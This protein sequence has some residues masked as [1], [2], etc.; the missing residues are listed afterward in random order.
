M[1]LGDH[2]KKS[3]RSG[4]GKKIRPA[5]ETKG[6]AVVGSGSR[7]D[8]FKR[9]ATR[10]AEGDM[11]V[12]PRMLSGNDRRLHVRQTI[13]E[14]HELRIDSR[15]ELAQE[16]FDKMAVSRYSF[17]R[18]TCLLFY[19]DMAGEDAWMPTVL[20]L[21]DVHPGNFGVMPSRDNVPFFGVN[22]F[23]ESYYAPFTWDLKRGALGFMLSVA[24]MGGHGHRLQTGA[25][26]TFVVGYLEA[27]QEYATGKHERR[28][29]LR[30]DNAPPLIANLLEN[31]GRTSR[32]RWLAD[33]YLDETGLRFRNSEKLVPV[34]S[35]REEFQA[36][37]DR[38]VRDNELSPPPRAAKMRVKDVCV[39]KGQGTASLGLARYYV[40]IEGPSGDASDDIVLELK[41]ARMSAL[42]GLV[43][44]SPFAVDGRADRIVH[45]QR[46]QLVR[47]DVFYGRVKFDGHS[48]MVRERSPFRDSIDVEELSPDQWFEYASVCGRALAH[49]H[50]LSDDSGLIDHDVEPAILKS[51]GDRDL[52]IKDIVR[53]ARAARRRLKRDLRY[54]IADHKDGA[55]TTTDIVYR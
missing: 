20:T 48:F 50:A 51:V 31:A 45:A 53:F 24:E 35:R 29:Q 21:G 12:L 52:F 11:V 36:I 17:F 54:F 33:D 1:A 2:A 38:Y 55:F 44:P 14:D 9:L 46:V 25:V 42:A 3:R 5:D 10:R 26:K 8:A 37:I 7:F 28:E 23:D 47:G 4:V 18:G 22:D 34:S 39:R 27:I 15:T 6:D 16:K 13:R 49:A 40:L 19:R 41:Q 32:A 30:A 43:P